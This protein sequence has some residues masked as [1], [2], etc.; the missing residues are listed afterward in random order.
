[1]MAFMKRNK[2]GQGRMSHRGEVKN[3]Q[4]VG[5]VMFESN[6]T[7]EQ[8]ESFNIPIAELEEN[9]M[10]KMFAKEQEHL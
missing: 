7:E 1:M 9:A 3:Y 4:A 5:P 6:V 2:V 10:I 8:E